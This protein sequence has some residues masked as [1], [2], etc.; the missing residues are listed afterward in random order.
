VSRVA[1]AW[2]CD[3]DYWQLLASK[4]ELEA[5]LTTADAAMAGTDLIKF[6]GPET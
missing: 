6:T 3:G 2:A 4:Q 5:M 1:A